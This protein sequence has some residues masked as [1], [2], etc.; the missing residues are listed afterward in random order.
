MTRKEIEQYG[1]IVREI[2]MWEN[3]LAQL[4]ENSKAKGQPTYVIGGRSGLTSDPTGM[5]G[6]SNAEIEALISGLKA[7]AEILQ[8]DIIVLIATID[9]SMLRQIIN[10]RC[11]ELLPWSQVAKRVGGGNTADSCRMQFKRSFEN[12]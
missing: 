5:S 2:R 10:Y 4:E 9:D 6:T 7:E 11:L 8:K 1:H 12:E 3:R